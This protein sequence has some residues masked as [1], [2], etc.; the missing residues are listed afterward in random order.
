MIGLDF[1][2]NVD[3]D[4]KKH[5]TFADGSPY[6]DDYCPLSGSKCRREDCS[7]WNEISDE[8]GYLCRIVPLFLT[9]LS[10]FASETVLM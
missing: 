8:C 3:K 2:K 5:V 4:W 7:F 6:Y 9:A 1:V 10:C